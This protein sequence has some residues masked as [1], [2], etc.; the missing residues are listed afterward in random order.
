MKAQIKWSYCKITLSSGICQW[1]D[2]NNEEV[3]KL[4]H[5]EAEASLWKIFPITRHRVISR[6]YG[7]H[8][9]LVSKSSSMSNI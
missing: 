4:K 7:F 9:Y 3:K 1:K 5:I 8:L 6:E 2:V